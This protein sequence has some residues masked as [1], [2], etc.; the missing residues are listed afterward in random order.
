MNRNSHLQRFLNSNNEYLIKNLLKDKFILDILCLI[1]LCNKTCTI[2]N[3]I[4]YCTSDEYEHKKSIT[5]L[6]DVLKTL[7]YFKLIL[8]NNKIVKL[9]R[10]AIQLIELK[11][12]VTRAT[13][14][15]DYNYINIKSQF[16]I[17]ALIKLKLLYYR[18]GKSLDLLNLCRLEGQASAIKN[19]IIIVDGNIVI[20]FNALNNNIEKLRRKANLILMNK[21][22]DLDKTI[23]II[24]EKDAYVIDKNTINQVFN[25]FKIKIM[26]IK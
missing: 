10:R 17:S 16:I 21:T 18:A 3:L 9:N 4:Y 23:N 13:T 15:L 20:I 19:D 8:M 7:V 1:Y 22:I 12:N 14:S 5:H 2:D 24:Y 25:Q 26:T 11:K 6:K